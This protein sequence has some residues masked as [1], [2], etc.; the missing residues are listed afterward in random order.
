MTLSDALSRFHY[1]RRIPSWGALVTI[2]AHG[3]VDVDGVTITDPD[4]TDGDPQPLVCARHAEHEH[5]R[6]AGQP[7]LAPIE[8]PHHGAE[9]ARRGMGPPGEGPSA[10]EHHDHRS[11]RHDHRLDVPHNVLT[12]H[13]A[14]VTDPAALL[15]ILGAIV[16][17]LT[18]ALVVR[19]VLGG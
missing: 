6:P 8:H 13:G 7:Q 16:S 19:S 12:H 17:I 1:W 18:T 10:P 11:D 9:L 5:L 4:D 2:D 15:S 14:S 3:R